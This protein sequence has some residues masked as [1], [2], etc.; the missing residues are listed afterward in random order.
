MHLHDIF[1]M[2]PNRLGPG[3]NYQLVEIIQLLQD[4][5]TRKAVVATPIPIATAVA[6]PRL[7]RTLSQIINAHKKGV[8]ENMKKRLENDRR[9]K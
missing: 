3:G 6:I 5:I 1:E 9:F 4:I 8:V 7:S 2:L